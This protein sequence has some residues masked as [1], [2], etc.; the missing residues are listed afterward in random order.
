MNRFLAGFIFFFTLFGLYAQSS[1]VPAGL[2]WEAGDFGVSITKYRGSA[3]L[4]RI[5]KRVHGLTLV[6]TD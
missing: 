6:F 2:E 4:F 1:G 3:D 5:I